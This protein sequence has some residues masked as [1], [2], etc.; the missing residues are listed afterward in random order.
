MLGWWLAER[1]LP[2]GGLNGRPEKK[3][4]VGSALAES[5]ASLLLLSKRSCCVTSSTWCLAVAGVL[6][7]VGAV[8]AG[9]AG[10]EPSLLSLN[11][12]NLMRLW[13][14]RQDLVDRPKEAGRIHHRGAGAL[15]LFREDCFG[16]DRQAFC[17]DDKRG[18]IADRPGNMADPFHTFFG[19]AGLSLLGYPGFTAIDPVYAL[20]VRVL[21]CCASC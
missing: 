7:L 16:V 9:H 4:D 5:V 20:P 3:E 1:Q 11:E 14:R 21:A 17:Q 18:G 12:L 15:C 13:F 6:Q 8:L 2:C 19:I 10:W